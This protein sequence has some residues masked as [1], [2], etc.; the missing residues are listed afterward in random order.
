M[1]T[2]YRIP[3][4]KFPLASRFA[5]QENSTNTPITEILVNSLITSHLDGANV[6]GGG[7]IGIGGVAWDGGYGV[8][9]V[10][11]STDEG[12]GWL[13]ATLG[14][15]LGRFAFRTFSFPVSGNS[16]GKRVVMARATNRIGQTQTTEPIQNPAGYH[17]NVMHSIAFNVT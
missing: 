12:R 2:A 8:R 4:G 3:L 9:S 14:E 17:H 15:D 6:K 10:E 7:S 1:N 13:P 5:S 11:I 16:K